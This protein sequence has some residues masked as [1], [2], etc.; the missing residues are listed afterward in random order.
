M[1]ES[2]PSI[3]RDWIRRWLGLVIGVALCL[4]L[5]SIYSPGQSRWFSILQIAGA[6]VI[7]GL[8]IYEFFRR[9]TPRTKG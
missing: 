8:G 5:L 1:S 9:E 4:L 7:L 2:F 6:V 3:R